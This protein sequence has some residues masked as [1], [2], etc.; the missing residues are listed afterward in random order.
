MPTTFYGEYVY[1]QIHR[2]TNGGASSNYIYSGISD[3]NNCALFI[4]PF[5]LDPNN[6][7]R[8]L[9][10]GCSLWRSNN[11]KAAAPTWTRIKPAASGQISAVAVAPGHPNII[12]V[13]YTN[14]D[15]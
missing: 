1:L 2:S 13:G 10:G 8:M 4:A 9:A 12:W 14:G 15:V 11:V 5:I 7:N 3:A 6:P